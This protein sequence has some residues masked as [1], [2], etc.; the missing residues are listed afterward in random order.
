MWNMIGADRTNAKNV[1][2]KCK[3]EIE[4]SALAT[5]GDSLFLYVL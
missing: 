4:V 5:Y 2:F 3:I 1:F